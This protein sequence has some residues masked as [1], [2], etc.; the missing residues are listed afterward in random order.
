M[1]R[2][3]TAC[4]ALAV[5]AGAAAGAGGQGTAQ[6]QSQDGLAAL[7]QIAE[8]EGHVR[9]LV[10]IAAADATGA[11][12]DPGADPSAGLDQARLL[13]QSAL[14]MDDAPLVEPIAD[15]P[16]MVME[17]SSRG[18]DWLAASPVVE[19]IEA[20]GLTGIPPIETDPGT[21]PSGE[22]DGGPSFGGGGTGDLAAP[23]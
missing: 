13:L 6:T 9:V 20:D 5:S 17:V 15:Q 11:E 12:A 14:P 21:D 19:R 23:Q 8:A 3:A 16:F 10:R 7:R 2:F 18:L 4:L 1:T 22:D